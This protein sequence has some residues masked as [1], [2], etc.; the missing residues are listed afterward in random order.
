MIL[1]TRE[2]LD[3]LELFAGH[4]TLSYEDCLLV[5]H[6]RRDGAE[7]LWTF[8]QKLANQTSAQLIGPPAFDAAGGERG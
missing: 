7:P 6:A 3:A 5:A 1:A 8:D 2:S 4:P